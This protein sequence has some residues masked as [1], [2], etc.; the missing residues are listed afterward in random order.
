MPSQTLRSLLTMLCLTFI[1]ASSGC[2]TMSRDAIPAMR[3][4]V[5][6]HAPTR[7]GLQPIN[8]ALLEGPKVQ[9]HIIDQ[10]DVLA[11]TIE[12]V[13]PRD[14][15]ELPPI[16]AG[17]ASLS[18]REYYPADG[19]VNAPSFGVPI[20][21]R[22]DGNI[23]LPL[24]APLNVRGK[25]LS[26]A[27]DTIRQRYIDEELS[28]KEGSQ[29]SVTLLKSRVNRVM[30]FREETA[31]GVSAVPPAT[32]VDLPFYESDVL[33]AL[34]T[35]GGLPRPEA[36]NRIWVLRK[37]SPVLTDMQAISPSTFGQDA[38]ATSIP[39]KVCSTE[40]IPFT[41]QDVM[42]N[43]G[44]VIY[45]EMRRNDFFYTGGL[46]PGMQIPLPRDEDIDVLEAVALANGSVG[47]LG[48]QASATLLRAGAGLGNIIPPTR[49]IV[50]RKLPNGQQ[51]LIRVNLTRA[52]RNPS[53]RLRIMPG[54]FVMM[55]Y[56][57][58]ESIVNGML[59]FFNIN[60]VK[61]ID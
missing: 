58:E 4:P 15:K 9:N 55:Y 40:M 14:P 24:V 57:P 21:V 48:G 47:G 53:E 44:D 26:Q 60:L 30:V 6:Y 36:Y 32:I 35:S 52:L 17:Q 29:I 39:L 27:A 2:I 5:Q 28:R 3:L 25:T 20:E 33:H 41:Q 12:G 56:K 10:G 49:L 51:L 19:S 54:D 46:L 8:F 42:L 61:T 16:I 59:N 7:E 31:E 18:A 11:I 1:A 13:I 37:T 50:V 43:E 38:T 23:E 34:A 22:S 45:I